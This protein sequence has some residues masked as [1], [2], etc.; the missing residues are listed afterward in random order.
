MFDTADG[1]AS[2]ATYG[3]N[4]VE[5]IINRET[6]VLGEYGQVLEKRVEIVMRQD[7]ASNLKRGQTITVGA[8]TYTVDGISYEDG[9]V[10]R[11]WV[12]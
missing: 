5:V 12:T 11:A 4:E 10:V 3:G 8:T 6:P 1:F 7:Q 2:A 9:T